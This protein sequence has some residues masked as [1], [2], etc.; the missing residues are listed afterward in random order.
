MKVVTKLEEHVRQ[1]KASCV[2]GIAYGVFMAIN[3]L[4]FSASTTQIISNAGISIAEIL[5]LVFALL[6][7][8]MLILASV[9]GFLKKYKAVI[10]FAIIA[11]VISLYSLITNISTMLTVMDWQHTLVEVI[12][13]IPASAIPAFF[14]AEAILVQKDLKEQ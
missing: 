4:G 5:V 7:P 14:I 10:V 13:M 12:M 6:V 8:A 9:F 2:I 11:F 1:F 3:A